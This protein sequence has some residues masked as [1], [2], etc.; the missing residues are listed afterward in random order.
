VPERAE[1]V[2]ILCGGRGTRLQEHTHA[3]PKALVEIGGRP[4]LWHVIRI[5]ASHGFRRFLLLTGY[6][7]EMIAG[8]AA[9]EAWPPGVAVECLETGEETQTGGRIA[10]AANRIG[11]GTFALSRDLAQIA[12]VRQGQ[13][14]V[15]SLS[16]PFPIRLT[17]LPDGHRPSAPG[18]S[19]DGNFKFDNDFNIVN[20]E[21][22]RLQGFGFDPATGL[23]SNGVPTRRWA[24]GVLRVPS[25]GI[26]ST[27]RSF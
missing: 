3:I 25:T 17:S 7:G 15:S 5:Y 10:L 1:T 16:R 27:V 12:Y 19:R 23:Q 11:D 26:Q 22:L 14:T 6:R 4:I 8:F 13:L 18:F 9:A 20:N 24:T 2:A 21:G